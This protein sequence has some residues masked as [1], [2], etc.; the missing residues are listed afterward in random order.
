MN[1]LSKTLVVVSLLLFHACLANATGI[2]EISVDSIDT[3]YDFVSG[4]LQFAQAG[5]GVV[6][7][8][9]GNVQDEFADAW[10]SLTTTLLTDHSFGGKAIGDF[11]GGSIVI[12]DSL[13]GLLLS[14]QIDQFRIEEDTYL[15]F[16]VLTGAGD[17]L[18]ADGAW[19]DDFGPEG[20]IFS[21]TWK[22]DYNIDSFGEDFVA[23]SDL[24]MMVPEPATVCAITLGALLQVMH[25][26]RRKLVRQ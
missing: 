26:K 9:P 4:Q 25:R 15:P 20:I 18:V 19:K 7:E 17:F 6:V 1:R 10:F 3:S 16:C 11:A 12:E 23:E 2:E 24:S 5:V 14:A 13:G 22:L 8:R 21:L